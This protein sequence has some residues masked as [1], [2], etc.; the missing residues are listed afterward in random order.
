M[1][2]THRSLGALFGLGYGAAASLP[3]AGV[4]GCGLL[5]TLTASGPASPDLDQ[6]RWWRRAD[7][8]TP[9]EW[10][11][12]HGPMQHRG[13]THWWGL[14]AAAVLGWALALLPLAGTGGRGDL[15]A[16]GTAALLAGWWSHLVGDLVFGKADVRGGR[17][18]GIPLMPWWGHV[19]VALD[20]GGRLERLTHLGLGLLAVVVVL[21]ET[22]VF[23]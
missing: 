10:L 15:F 13:L 4:L 7:R 9:D 11:G 23:G 8:W 6:H 21:A 16:H 19:G 2:S 20:V 17:G 5:G 12:H 14:A 1:G 18:P 22:G 3:F